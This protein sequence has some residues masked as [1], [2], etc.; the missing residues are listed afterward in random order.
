MNTDYKAKLRSLVFNLKDKTNP[1]LRAHVLMGEVEPSH[2]VTMSA[3]DLANKDRAEWRRRVEEEH[4]K[5]IE[6]DTEA[7]AK[8]R[9]WLPSH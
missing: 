7:A 1:D 6:L 8:V 4:N 5:A 9:L 3:G 2:L